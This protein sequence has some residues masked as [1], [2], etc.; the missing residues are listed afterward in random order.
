MTLNNHNLYNGQLIAADSIKQIDWDTMN[1]N[2]MAQSSFNER[3]N[4]CWDRYARYPTIGEIDESY[5]AELMPRLRL[6]PEMSVMDVGCGNGGI[7]IALANRVG[8]VVSLDHSKA[9]LESLENKI[10]ESNC[11]N[12]KTIQSDFSQIEMGKDLAV[13]DVVLASRSLPMGNLRQSLDKINLAAR[14][15]CY[16]VLSS[17][18]NELSEW[19]YGKM[20]FDYK[21]FP[22]YIIIPNLLCTMG[23]HAN[24]EIFDVIGTYRFDDLDEILA[25]ASFGKDITDESIR[26][27]MIDLV[28]SKVAYEEGQYKYAYHKQFALIWWQKEPKLEKC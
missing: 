10:K 7:S 12:I 16:V 17:T 15:L 21:P 6:S 27:K 2:Q 25:F 19:L 13:C 5:M 9:A 11:K 14:Q 26:K 28:R 23:I 22:E 18:S 3:S 24:V 20:G 1:A 8:Q 4:A